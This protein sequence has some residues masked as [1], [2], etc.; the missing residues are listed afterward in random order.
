MSLRNQ[1]TFGF[2]QATVALI[3]V[4][5]TKIMTMIVLARLLTP[6]IFG[7]FA[8]ANTTIITITTLREIGFGAAYIQRIDTDEKDSKTAIDTAFTIGLVVDL[9]ILVTLFYGAPVIADF[10]ESKDLINVLR[11]MAVL[12]LIEPV[13]GICNA[14]LVKRLEFGRL[15]NAEIIEVFTFS[16][17][18]ITLAVL[19][20]EIWGIIIGII[21]SKIT[22]CILLIKFSNWKP[23]FK[24]EKNMARELFGFGKFMWAFGALSAVGGA[25]D[26][27]VI[28]KYWGAV[29]LGY[30]H[31]AF[32]LCSLPASAFSMLINKITFPAFSKLQKNPERMKG[33]LLKIISNVSLIVL[34]ASLGL[35]VTADEL[36]VTVLGQQWK[37]TIPFVRILAIYGLTLSISA[38]TGPAFQ[39]LG[40]PYVLFY[41]SIN[42][43]IIMITLLLL[44]RKYGVIGICYAVLIPLIISSIIA[45]IL[46][47]RYLDIR[48]KELMSAVSMPVILSIIM[49]GVIVGL[50]YGSTMIQNIETELMLFIN[51]LIGIA[52]YLILS[53]LFNKKMLNEFKDS[54]LEIIKSKKVVNQ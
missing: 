5:I 1:V 7:I 17:V 23:S 40:K 39:A 24:I 21:I 16:I 25:L 15:A 50:R 32:N 14:I 20:F 37:A 54:A 12:F 33:A 9:M 42:H 28:G 22:Y 3:V 2:K 19:K 8:M 31:L 49:Y 47:V 52:T 43:H 35:M 11:F 27:V 46:I 45:F 18:A 30:Y 10:F 34:P 26:R 6:E 51:V 29:N 44:F 48:F 36:I 53:I 41:T 38:T 13:L 4:R